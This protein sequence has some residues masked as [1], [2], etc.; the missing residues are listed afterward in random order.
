[1]A[2][3]SRGPGWKQL[4]AAALMGVELSSEHLLC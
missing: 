2:A 4:R 3:G 1:M